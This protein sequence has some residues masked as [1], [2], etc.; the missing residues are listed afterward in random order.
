MTVRG[1]VGGVN[2]YGKIPGFFLRLP[3]KGTLCEDHLNQRWRMWDPTSLDLVT[4]DQMHQYCRGRIVH[5]IGN[6]MIF[7]KTS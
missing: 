3:F 7:S 4:P 6:I 2:P 5:V 1:G